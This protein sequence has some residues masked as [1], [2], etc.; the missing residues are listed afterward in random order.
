MRNKLL[1]FI[2]QYAMGQPGDKVVCA[3]SGGSDSMALLWSM[4][5]LKGKLGICLE[6]AHFNHNLRGAESERDEAFVRDF[7]KTHG[8]NC[9]VGRGEVVPGDKGLEAAAREARYRFLKTLPGM[10]A[11][12]HTADDNAETMLMHL[13]R[14]TGLK[15]LGGITPKTD[16]LIRPMLTVTR[17]EVLAFLE[18]EQIPYVTDSSNAT[19]DFLRN[20]IRHHVMP[21]LKQENPSLA[22]NLSVTALNLRQD[23]A[24]LDA[25]AE[26]TADVETLLQMEPALQSRALTKLLLSWGVP[27]PETGHIDLLRK[28]LLS[29][30]PSARGAF[31]G[32]IC[33]C[34]QYGKLVKL[35]EK[36][37]L[38]EII[39]NNPGVT[40]I[41]Q[42][43]ITVTC[44]PAETSGNGW[45]VYAEGT[46]LL[47]S[48][49]EGDTIVLPGGTKSLKKLFIDRK[50]PASQRSRIPV[51]ADSLG[52]VGVAGIGPSHDRRE[53][54]NLRIELTTSAFAE[55]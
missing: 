5:L 6:A 42:W 32:N 54:P 48:R 12:A 44:A 17:R 49:K 47:R 21:L 33:I 31:P 7:C 16:R 52:V 35:E 10:I 23:A 55:E 19:D 13:V 43:G 34:R 27:E 25:L 46:L 20:R 40:R 36:E 39:L 9:H 15:G 8:I 50:I 18:A 4:Y 22:E 2:R 51:I 28:L 11:T 53:T 37:E 3:V 26:P 30:N 38:P 24:A 41:P 29:D 14:G 1:A 45:K